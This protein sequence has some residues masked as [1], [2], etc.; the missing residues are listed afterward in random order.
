MP[1]GDL[2]GLEEIVLIDA[3]DR[4]LAVNLDNQAFAAGDDFDLEPFAGR[5]IGIVLGGNRLAE[6]L[7]AQ[8]EPAGQLPL[9]EDHFATGAAIAGA[10]EDAAGFGVG[11]SGEAPLPCEG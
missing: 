7:A 4:F 8:I 11:S 5:D 10:E 3:I 6:I 1:Q 2:T 9:A